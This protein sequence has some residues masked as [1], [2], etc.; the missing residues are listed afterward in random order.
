MPSNMQQ[1]RFYTKLQKRANKIL[2]NE[3][4]LDND[5]YLS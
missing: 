2:Y 3:D 5:R 1:N 4:I